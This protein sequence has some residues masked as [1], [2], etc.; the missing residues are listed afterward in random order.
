[1][2]LKAYELGPLVVFAPNGVTAKSFAAPTIRPNEEWRADVTG[3]VALMADRREDLDH[4]LDETKT[5][6]YI[7][8]GSNNT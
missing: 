7:H 5:E 6:T 8:S 2:T 1:M 4:L 3:W